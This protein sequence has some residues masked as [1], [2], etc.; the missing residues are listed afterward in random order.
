MH[1]TSS[2]VITGTKEIESLIEERGSIEILQDDDL[3]KLYN[4]TNF[5]NTLENQRYNLLTVGKHTGFHY[6]SFQRMYVK[7]FKHGVA[8]NGRPHMQNCHRNNEKYA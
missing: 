8:Q 7:N 6:E 5:A 4:D 1:N 3:E 2:I